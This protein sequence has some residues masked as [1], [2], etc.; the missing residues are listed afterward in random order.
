MKIKKITK[1]IPTITISLITTIAILTPFIYI[2]TRQV[3]VKSLSPEIEWVQFVNALGE[4]V[5]NRKTTCIHTYWN[6]KGRKYVKVHLK[7]NKE[8][9]IHY[10]HSDTGKR[11][12]VLIEIDID[13]KTELVRLRL[14]NRKMELAS[15]SYRLKEIVGEIVDLKLQI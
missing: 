11:R 13:S 7:N 2:E 6:E 1:L 5:S 4:P 9:T 3:N 14:L 8:F 12:R 10:F 15:E